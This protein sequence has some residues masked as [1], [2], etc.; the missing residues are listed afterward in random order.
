M[1][2][3][4]LN[5]SHKRGLFSVF[6]KVS[7]LS[8]VCVS[9][10]SMTAAVSCSSE[11]VPSSINAA[12]NSESETNT[13]ST[14]SNTAASTNGTTATEADD[15]TTTVS[16]KNPS[17]FNTY[18][19]DEL[20]GE[21]SPLIGYWHTEGR[22]M[23]IEYNEFGEEGFTVFLLG[24]DFQIFSSAIGSFSGSPQNVSYILASSEDD[25]DVANLYNKDIKFSMAINNNNSISVFVDF[26]FGKTSTYTLE[27]AHP[28]GEAIQPFTGEWGNMKGIDIGF[29][30]EDGSDTIDIQTL[31]GFSEDMYP[32][33]IPSTFDSECW[34]CCPFS[35]GMLTSFS[36]HGVFFDVINVHL[37]PNEDGSI[38]AEREYTN[39]VLESDSFL[40]SS[41]KLR[42]VE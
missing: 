13:A 11:K 31:F 30:F 20:F 25:E 10:T 16:A 1:E 36:E 26:G 22:D 21:K 15:E 37:I 7:A 12:E 24:K 3:K 38:T 9:L 2:N 32:I 35:K 42:K 33:G 41:S 40:T 19:M 23:Y 18:S 5:N 39:P 8:L 6:S 27:K 28:D 4:F 14:V 29:T 34:I 17:Q